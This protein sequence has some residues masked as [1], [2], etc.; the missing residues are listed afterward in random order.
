MFSPNSESTPV[1]ML[2]GIVRRTLSHGDRT[3]LC[4]ITLAKGA[5]LPEH[6]HEH[7]QVGYMVRGRMLLRIA[8]EEREVAAGDGYLIPS[9]VLHAVTALADSVAIDIFSPPRKEYL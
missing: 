1:E 9:N 3:M 7:E 5:I 6:R 8:D 2:P 4:E